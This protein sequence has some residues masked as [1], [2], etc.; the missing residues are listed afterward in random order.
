MGNSMGAPSHET[1]F[2]SSTL[3]QGET[4]S[5]LDASQRGRVSG[6]F[7]L[8]DELPG[9]NNVSQQVEAVFSHFPCDGGMHDGD[10]HS[11]QPLGAQQEQG[12]LPGSFELPEELPQTSQMPLDSRRSLEGFLTVEEA[13][14]HSKMVMDAFMASFQRQFQPFNA[15]KVGQGPVPNVSKPVESKTAVSSPGV[16]YAGELPNTSWAV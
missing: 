15:G 8:P 9:T 11:P 14:A 6:S 4:T 10:C 16:Y 3:A 12:R 1:D 5:I 13:L 2:V 7:E